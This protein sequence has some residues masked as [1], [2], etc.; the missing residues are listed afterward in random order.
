[1]DLEKNRILG[2]TGLKV[3]R[4]GVAAS[5]GA[6]TRSIEEAFDRGCNYFYWGSMR[7]DNMRQ[8]II[9]ICG[10][11]KRDELIIVL[12]SYSRSAILMEHFFKR[13]LKAIALDHADVLLLGWYNRKPSRRIIDK[14][15]DMKERGLFRFLAISGH[16]RPLFPQ[17]AKKGI[18]DIFHIRYNAAHRGAEEDVFPHLPNNDRP[19][20]VTYT[21]TRWGNLLNPKKMPPGE[22]TP[23]ASDWYRFVITN[24]DIDVCMSGPKNEDEMK[25][26]LRTIDLG[27]LDTDALERMRRI[28]AFVHGKGKSR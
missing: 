1:M 16:K 7:K 13:A 8:A 12:Q 19:G 2:C 25:E 26:A 11:G 10:R 5:Y 3:G 6:P 22:T 14:A 20:I 24:P 21:A 18:F 9:N 23:T 17:L 28:G 27:P 4:L 15:L